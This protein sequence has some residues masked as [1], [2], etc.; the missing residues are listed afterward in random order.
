MDN[1]LTF[2]W[3]GLAATGL[4]FILLNRA[5]LEPA[6]RRAEIAK[7]PERDP[8]PVLGKWTDAWAGQ[9]PMTPTGRDDIRSELRAAGYYRPTALVEYAAVR[10]LLVVV[11]L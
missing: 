1:W 3:I 9:L 8:E 10:A 5:W 6:R 11:P 2:A 7:D 4:T